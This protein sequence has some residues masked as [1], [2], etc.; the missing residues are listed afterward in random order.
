MEKS[1]ELIKGIVATVEVPLENT[2]V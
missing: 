2:Q 1:V